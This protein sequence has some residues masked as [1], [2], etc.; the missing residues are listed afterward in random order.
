MFELIIFEILN[1][2]SKETRYMQWHVTLT[3]MLFDLIVL[4]PVLQVGYYI[5]LCVA[6]FNCICG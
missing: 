4:L 2:L 1:V 3:A 6:V 5:P